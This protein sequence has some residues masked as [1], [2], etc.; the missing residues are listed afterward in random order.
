GAEIADRELR[1]VVEQHDHLVDDG[2]R[3]RPEIGDDREQRDRR[4][5]FLAAR[6]LTLLPGV[7]DLLR[8]RLFGLFAGGLPAHHGVPWMMPF[9]S[10]SGPPGSITERSWPMTSAMNSIWSAACGSRIEK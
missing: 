8:C 10:S 1:R 6:H 3:G 9:G 4:H 7:A 2:A 5:H